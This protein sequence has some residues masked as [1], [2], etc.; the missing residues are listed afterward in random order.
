MLLV[1]LGLYS[2]L[3]ASS[4]SSSSL[5]SSLPLACCFQTCSMTYEALPAGSSRTTA[6]CLELLGSNLDS[7]F[8]NDF[9]GSHLP[10]R[11]PPSLPPQSIPQSHP[12]VPLPKQPGGESQTL[13]KPSSRGVKTLSAWL[14]PIWYHSKFIHHIIVESIHPCTSSVF[15]SCLAKL[16]KRDRPPNLTFKQQSQL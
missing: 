13:Q 4:S 10:G 6:L 7:D 9:P 12:K 1:S 15:L 8:R 11:G 5:S 16:R 3:S 2:H 14:W